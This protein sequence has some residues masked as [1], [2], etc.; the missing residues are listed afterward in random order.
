MDIINNNNLFQNILRQS[1]AIKLNIQPHNLDILN[2]N[3]KLDNNISI[4]ILGLVANNMECKP[5]VLVDLVTEHMEET[6]LKEDMAR[7]Q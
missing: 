7:H 3:S 5:K 1:L 6:E 2:N 4:L